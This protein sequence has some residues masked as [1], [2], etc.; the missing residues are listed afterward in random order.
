MKRQLS[1][2]NSREN[3]HSTTTE[4]IVFDCSKHNQQAAQAKINPYN[5][6]SISSYKSATGS[7]AAQTMYRPGVTS[8]IAFGNQPTSSQI[9]RGA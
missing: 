7:F 6:S 2:S 1:H 3:I 5:R 4:Q 9:F 8:S